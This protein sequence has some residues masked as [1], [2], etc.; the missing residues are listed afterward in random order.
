MPGLKPVVTVA[1]ML[2]LHVGPALE[3]QMPADGLPVVMPESVQVVPG[4]HYGA[5]RVHR[6]LFGNHYRNLW[7]TPIPAEVLDLVHFGGGLTPTERGGG[8]QTRS[9][10]FKA[11]D[12]REFAFRSVE[13]D[14]SVVLPE[15]LR[16]TVA[17]EILQDQISSSH[18]AG[19][20]VAPV[21]LR[22]AGV[23]HAEPRLVVLPDSPRLGE[24]QADFGGTLGLFEERPSTEG[25]IVPGA[26]RV[27][28]SDALFHRVEESADDRVDTRALLTARL[29]D[30]YL[31]DW[32][33]HRDQWRWATYD[34]QPPRRWVPIPRDRDQAFVRFDG[35]LLTLARG[36]APQLVNFGPRYPAAVGLT[37]NGRE[38]DRRFLVSLERAAWD[39]TASALQAALTDAVIDSAVAQLPAAYATLDGAR[40]AAAL[41]ARR[42]HLPELA[43]RFY[44]LLAE[45]V[46]VH[47]TDEADLVRA[48]PVGP[49]LLR[50]T[51]LH[52][53]TDRLW[54]DRS[55]DNRETGEV[56]VYLHGGADLAV[57]SGG[58]TAGINLRFIGG[59]GRDSLVDSTGGHVRFYDADMGTVVSG[60]A[61]DARPYSTGPRK[62]ETALPPRDWGS[63]VLPLLWAGGGP[64]V[65]LLVGAGIMWTDFGFR[66]QPYA[67]EHRV[68]IG[69]AT[70]ASEAKGEYH[71]VFHGEGHAR[72]LDLF[73]RASGIETLRF[74]GFGNETAITG[75][76]S[77]YRVRQIELLFEPSLVF[78]LGSDTR[79]SLGPSVRYSNTKKGNRFIDQAQPYGADHFGMLGGKAGLTVD[80]RDIPANATHGVRL[81]LGGAVFPGIWDVRSTFAE[82]H[83][84]AST[85][86]SARIPA[87]PVLALRVGGKQIL[88]TAPYHEA[89]YIGDLETVRLGRENR[90]GGDAA[91]WGNAELRLAFG[92]Y[93]IIAPGQWGVFGLGDVGRVFLDGESSR[94]WHGAYGG[95]LW[96]GFLGRANTVSLA[97]AQS[98]ER[99]RI[100]L[101][102]GMAY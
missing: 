33:R 39:S 75:S 43:V 36:Q 70:G 98:S 93:R 48:E 18:P 38:L 44:R 84:S 2:A 8:Q 16:G 29:M 102:A 74:H 71:G 65:G 80:S 77:F 11:A 1:V 96:F 40:L 21:L 14:P 12:G 35:L 72:Y 42:D 92:G 60:A 85:Y 91:V 52:P 19:A 66:Q 17:N 81:E 9:L 22:A 88:G 99:A 79:F 82:L 5:G 86:L 54:F 4:A 15:E 47:A 101:R 90:F 69:Y 100:Y 56:R 49:H 53:G 41:R 32:D 97:W 23:P 10:R 94:V 58:S 7:T 95:G 20:L 89:A 64:D 68:R 57:A 50:L 27:I 45:E 26:S 51:I 55:F 25:D 24:F 61:L 6:L 83:G 62:S 63:R 76:T 37:W 31:G 30:A 87:R 73:A 34:V 28:S 78:P 3:A 67:S 59:G 13:K 46:D